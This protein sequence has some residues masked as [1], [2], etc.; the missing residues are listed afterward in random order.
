MC[1]NPL[2][3]SNNFI[4][5]ALK[6]NIPLSPMKLQKMLYFTYR[7][8]LKATGKSLF[9][10]RFGTWQYGPVLESVYDAFKHYGSRSIER[11]DK[12]LDDEAEKVSAYKVNERSDQ[13]LTAVLD[14]VWDKAKGM[15]GIALSELTHLPGSAWYKAFQ[16]GQPF[17]DDADIR[18]DEIEISAAG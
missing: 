16:K 18:V 3:V 1:L 4:D 17:L 9:A 7:D 15:S 5:R 12:V 13:T 8:Y 14:D 2:F 10:E 6:T 11:Y